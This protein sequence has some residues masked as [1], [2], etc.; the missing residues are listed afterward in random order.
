MP[1]GAIAGTNSVVLKLGDTD[2]IATRDFDVRLFLCS[3]FQ[4]RSWLCDGP[5][6]RSHYFTRCLNLPFE[7]LTLCFTQSIRREI[8]G[9]CA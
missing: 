1:F 2:S 9:V 6:S 7:I 5:I 8:L 4:W 3:V